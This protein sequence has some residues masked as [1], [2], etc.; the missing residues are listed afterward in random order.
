MPKGGPISIRGAERRVADGEVRDLKPGDYLS[1]SV[2]D[3][4]TGMDAETL[5]RATEP[6]FTTK[7]VGKGTGLGLSMIHGLARQLGGTFAL[8]SVPGEGT[9]ATMLLPVAPDTVTL[10]APEPAAD[11]APVPERLKIFAVDDGF[12][13]LMNTTALLEDLGHEVY[14]ARSGEEALALLTDIDEIDLLMTDQA[15]PNMTGL[16]LVDKLAE[17]RPDLPVIL[18]S[19]YGEIPSGTETPMFKLGKPFTQEQLAA[20]LGQALELGRIAARAR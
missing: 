1:L 19:G 13:I 10:K 2:I 9:V 11:A 16:Q 18:A 20:A 6:F 12:L 3:A 8:A 5:A 4:G 14:E 17:I 15:M 7:G